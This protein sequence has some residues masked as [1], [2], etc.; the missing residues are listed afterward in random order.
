MNEAMTS[1]DTLRA[2][3]RQDA[4]QELAACDALLG[5]LADQKEKRAYCQT[6]LEEIERDLGAP[7]HRARDARA[8]NA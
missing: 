7:A 1:T 8:G 6:R 2:A 4:A 5:K 3:V